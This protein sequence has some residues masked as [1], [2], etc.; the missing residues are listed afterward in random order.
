MREKWVETY[1]NVSSAD[2]FEN[3]TFVTFFFNL[4]IYFWLHWDFVVVRG[5]SLVAE[6]GV[7]SSLQCVGFSLRWLLLWSMDSR[8]TGFSSCGAQAQ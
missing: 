4:F 3:G 1:I 8:H 6:S 7:Y 2:L 5:F